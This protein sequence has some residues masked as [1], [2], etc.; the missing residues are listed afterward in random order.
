[1]MYRVLV[2]NIFI[3]ISSVLNAQK[4]ELQL[5]ANA[6]YNLAF[7]DKALNT[8][9]DQYYDVW[10]ANTKEKFHK[11]GIPFQYQIGA[12]YWFL[13]KVG[14]SMY[15]SY[16]QQSFRTD[17]TNDESRSIDVKTRTPFEF[18]VLFGNPNKFYMG[19]GF[20]VGYSSF[21]SRYNYKGGVTSMG[22]ESAING[23]YSANGFSY[24]IDA[25]YKIY[26]NFKLVASAF[27][28]VGSEYT[29]KNFMKGIDVHGINETVYFPSDYALYKS[30]ME[31]G[32]SFDYPVSSIAKLNH[33]HFFVGL[34]YT[35]KL[36]DFVD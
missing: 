15:Y 11:V 24:N 13:D 29:D 28:I 5:F 33:F 23:V 9:F 26:K 19:I 3:G 7:S 22:Y 25:V 14:F 2:L 16:A 1:M 12:N 10:Q 27:G 35:A 32:T 6:G 31:G 18:S 4:G 17:F 30:M 34:Q 8:F 36:V 21:I 20:G